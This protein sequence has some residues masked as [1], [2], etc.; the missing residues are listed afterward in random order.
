MK[1]YDTYLENIA[2][3]QIALNSGMIPRRLREGI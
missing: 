1:V 3:Y 2:N